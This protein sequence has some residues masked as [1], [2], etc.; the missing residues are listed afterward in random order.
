MY[1]PH[2]AEPR[3]RRRS[4]AFA[5]D[6]D[7]GQQPEQLSIW[8]QYEQLFRDDEAVGVSAKRP[9]ADRAAKCFGIV[10]AYTFDDGVSVRIVALYS[11]TDSKLYGF[12]EV[13]PG[14]RDRGRAWRCFGEVE[15]FRRER[16]RELLLIVHSSACLFIPNLSR[17]KLKVAPA[18]C[19]TRATQLQSGGWRYDRLSQSDDLKAQEPRSC[20]LSHIS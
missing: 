13:P 20:A 14:E 10:G 8:R 7:F 6:R 12:C 2:G 19:V 1:C 11:T 15:L 5:A 16:S 9:W 4:A 18:D 17:G 3:K